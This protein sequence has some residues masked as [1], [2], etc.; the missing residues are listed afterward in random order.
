[1][2]APQPVIELRLDD[3]LTLRKPH[4]CGGRTWRVDRLGADI[5]LACESCG[6]RVL[7]ERRQV[8]RRL[9]GFVERGPAAA[10]GPAEAVEERPVNG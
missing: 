7:L 6:H 1:V 9:A 8:E 2:P 5:G 3:R 10:G 4:A